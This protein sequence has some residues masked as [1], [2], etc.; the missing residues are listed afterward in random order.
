MVD[1]TGAGDTFNGVFAAA[2]AGGST[3]VDAASRGVVAASLSVASIGART[4]MPRDE[5][6]RRAL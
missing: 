1:T 2:L 5:E 4:G 3:V 6:I